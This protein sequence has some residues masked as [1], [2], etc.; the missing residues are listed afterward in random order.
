M[1]EMDPNFVGATLIFFLETQCAV[2]DGEGAVHTDLPFKKQEL[3]RTRTR[4]TIY[5][6]GTP[7]GL[8]NSVEPGGIRALLQEHWVEDHCHVVGD[9]MPPSN[10]CVLALALLFLSWCVP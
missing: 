6:P 4:P 7:P 9:T 1:K 3:L 2:G 10:E 8:H 5:S